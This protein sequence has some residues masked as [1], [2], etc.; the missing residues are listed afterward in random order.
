MTGKSNEMKNSNALI[1][2][3]H[4]WDITALNDLQLSGTNSMRM[5]WGPMGGGLCPQP[6]TSSDMN[7]AEHLWDMMYR[8]IHHCQVTTQ[9]VQAIHTTEPF[10]SCLVRYV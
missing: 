5:A 10:V 3:S 2:Q 6:L 9:T 1:I 8:C 7:P 4:F